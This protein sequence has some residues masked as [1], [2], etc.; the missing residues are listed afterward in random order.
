MTS[1]T[2]VVLSM[3]VVGV[4]M[5]A[6]TSHGQ[7]SGEVSFR[8]I[9]QSAGLETEDLETFSQAPAWQAKDWQI[10]GQ[11]IH[12]LRQF[13]PE[14]LTTWAKPWEEVP[15]EAPL[16]GELIEI[17]GNAIAY[18]S[19]KPSE[20]SPVTSEIAELHRC[21]IKSQ[22]STEVFQ[23]LTPTVP[24]LWQEKFEL[25]EPVQVVGVVLQTS[26][27]AGVTLLANHVAWF[28][29]SGVSTGKL[30]LSQLGMDVALL[31]HV[32]QYR[33]FVSA[34]T[35]REG[36][37][38]FACLQVMQ[39]VKGEEL[40]RLAR[41]SIEQSAEDWAARLKLWKE[42]ANQ[43]ADSALRQNIKMAEA[44]LE[45]STLG[46]SS[47]APL[48]LMAEEQV[49]ELVYLEGI[50]R[51]AVRIAADSELARPEYFEIDLFTADSQNL[52]IVCCASE[53]PEDFPL[54][55]EIHER[56]RF[57]GVFF[58]NWRYRT[59]DIVQ[60]DAD[61]LQQKPG[62]VP[63]IIGKS[64]QVIPPIEQETSGW[65]IAGGVAVLLLLGVLLLRLFR[66][67]RRGR[68]A[69]PREQIDL[70]EP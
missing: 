32:N 18:E 58:K 63:V 47:V 51:R 26:E 59:R 30:L 48:F 55:D 64:P 3:G 69:R 39:E 38:F 13:A 31:D 6:R 27:S 29:N 50:A 68:I 56:V 23:V 25:P 53:L 20:D 49:G 60:E 2:L 61:E 41:Q 34:A 7:T 54:G 12:R 42:E 28:P 21:E 43:H 1:R 66:S 52:P 22:D 9:L 40:V 17:E 62:F 4:A 45:R 37:A 33:P 11:V 35:S 10:A 57:A 16:L 65:A 19:F 46:Q 8:E 24:I 70:P 5:F 36:E 67:E 14:Q 44:V 15:R